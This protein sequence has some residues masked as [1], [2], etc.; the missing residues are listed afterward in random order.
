[1]DSDAMPPPTL[2]D[3]AP[4]AKAQ[5][6]TRSYK[7]GGIAT[8]PPPP[9]F[10]SHSLP[11]SSSSSSAPAKSD[12]A[13]AAI[14]FQ[15]SR[16]RGPSSKRPSPL[17]LSSP[18][19]RRRCHHHDQGHPHRPQPLSSGP[20]SGPTPPLPSATRCDSSA[21]SSDH[22]DWTPILL[23]TPPPS[24]HTSKFPSSPTGYLQ[25]TSG[26]F[27]SPHSEVQHQLNRNAVWQSSPTL[28]TQRARRLSQH[29]PLPLLS[30]RIAPDSAASDNA[31]P[32]MSSEFTQSPPVAEPVKCSPPVPGT[33][34]SAAEPGASL[35]LKSMPPTKPRAHTLDGT[36]RPVLPP[37]LGHHLHSHLGPMRTSLRHGAEY[38]SNPY[39]VTTPVRKHFDYFALSPFSSLGAREHRSLS[40]FQGQKT[41]TSSIRSTSSSVSHANTSPIRPSKSR[42]FLGAPLQLDASVIGLCSASADPIQKEDAG[43]PGVASGSHLPSSHL[44]TPDNALGLFLEPNPFPSELLHLDLGP[45]AHGGPLPRSEADFFLGQCG[46]GSSSSSFLGANSRNPSHVLTRSPANMS[47]TS[48]QLPSPSTHSDDSLPLL[49]LAQRHDLNKSNIDPSLDLPALRLH[50]A[51]P[52]LAA[53]PTA[54]KSV[55]K[56]KDDSFI[57]KMPILRAMS[58]LADMS[59]DSEDQDSDEPLIGPSMPTLSSALNGSTSKVEMGQAEVPLPQE[60]RTGEIFVSLK[61]ILPLTYKQG[62]SSTT[63]HASAL[64]MESGLATVEIVDVSFHFEDEAGRR[65]D[66]V[67]GDLLCQAEGRAPFVVERFAVH[68]TAHV[69]NSDGRLQKGR[70][71]LVP[72]I[73]FGP[74]RERGPREAVQPVELR[75]GGTIAK[76]ASANEQAATRSGTI[77]AFRRVQIRSAT[78]NNGQRGAASQ[79]FY[80]LKLTLLAFPRQGAVTVGGGVEVASLISHPITVRGRSKVHYASAASAGTAKKDTAAAASAVPSRR[81]SVTPAANHAT[82]SS[83][84]TPKRSNHARSSSNSSMSPD[85]RRSSRRLVVTARA[86]SHEAADTMQDADDELEEGELSGSSA[87]WQRPASK[88]MD[89]RSII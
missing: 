35:S 84:F 13:S 15:T 26:C 4:S 8:L 68:M 54:A 23:L 52:S 57:Y 60:G 14:R 83:R 70:Q 18:S 7:H 74:A 63:E 53:P 9:P 69:V 85:Q 24:S 89:I 50:D 25:D 76:E 20:T 81:S 66:E 19:S 27:R 41:P 75:S 11:S 33:Q 44:T 64:S 88:V 29:T 62:G 79:Q 5:T 30:H 67:Q 17:L 2:A 86:T 65:R 71:G 59:S 31:D 38:R 82:T 87:T 77:A 32:S 80:A 12:S 3:Q 45:T 1:M 48:S 6:P 39:F 36:G 10:P 16:S 46:G 34:K 72:L 21:T 47:E 22:Y 51:L 43:S 73:Q 49:A 78:M 28:S 55:A 37:L 56:F 58:P 61:S 42:T 40:L